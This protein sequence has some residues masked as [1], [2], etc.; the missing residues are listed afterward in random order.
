MTG[1]IEAVCWNGKWVH[2]GDELDGRKVAWIEEIE[3]DLDALKYEDYVLEDAVGVIARFENFDSKA[4]FEDGM[5]IGLEANGHFYYLGQKLAGRRVDRI[6]PYEEKAP[7]ARRHAFVLRDK[8]MQQIPWEA[9]THKLPAVE[10]WY[11]PFE[12]F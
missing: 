5:L 6:L 12:P 7:S 11:Q 10:V 4:L 2:L 8:D 3:T 9:D 1:P